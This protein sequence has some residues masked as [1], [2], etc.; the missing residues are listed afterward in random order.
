MKQIKLNSNPYILK[1]KDYNT[2]TFS[3][4]FPYQYNS[5]HM[6]DI[7]LI[8]QI[9]MNSS[10]NY[11]TEQEY[12]L[13]KIK[14]LIINIKCNVE[15]YHNNL[16]F[17]FNCT[18]PD[19][20]K[21]NDF[22]L[23]KA[24]EFFYD[25][26]YHPNVINNEFNNKQFKREKDYVKSSIQEANKLIYNYSYQRFIQFADD[27]GDLK[28][29]VNNNLDLIEKSNPKD[30]Y[31]YYSDIIINNTPACVVYG[32]INKEEI[33]KVYYKY[34]KKENKE[35]TFSKDYVSYLKPS[36]NTNYIE[37]QS[38]YNQSVLYM[39]YKIE[40][41][42]NSDQL[43]LSLLSTILNN[44]STNLIFKKLRIENNLIYSYNFDRYIKKGIFYIEALINKTNK[45]KAISSIKEIFD[46]IKDE[47]LLKE[48]ISK[49]IKSLEYNQ[50]ELKD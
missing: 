13:E 25:T 24:F 8:K 33:D 39:A 48:Y 12:K 10:F 18:V 9:I 35:I 22:N 49:I 1:T 50:I 41:M 21:I 30:L 17:I 2:I 28:N 3:L 5:S 40:K 44:K 26:I 36:K 47:K 11:K 15:I 32:N 31:K 23:E 46:E 19:P 29:N 43:F 27:I 16:F 14:R 37:E 4:I 6:F 34:F 7:E 38:N 45:E 42:K 20:K